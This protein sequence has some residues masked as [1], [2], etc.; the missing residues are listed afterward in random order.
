[1]SGDAELGVKGTTEA[2]CNEGLV[3]ASMYWVD[4]FRLD[5]QI[6]FA[7]ESKQSSV[8]PHSVSVTHSALGR[9][10]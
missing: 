2:A 4:H 1:V 7:S 9:V 3:V 10:A 5:L 8:Q 6:H